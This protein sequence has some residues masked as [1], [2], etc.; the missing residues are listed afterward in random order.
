[1]SSYEG[2]EVGNATGF[3]E[4]SLIVLTLNTLT[5]FAPVVT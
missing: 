1:M 4:L 3:I 2:V 5:I